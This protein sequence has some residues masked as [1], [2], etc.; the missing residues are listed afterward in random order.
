MSRATHGGFNRQQSFSA[1]IRRGHRLSSKKF[2]QD[3]LSAELF[4]IVLPKN[5]SA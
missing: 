1:E 4:Q 5:Y 3:N 2:R